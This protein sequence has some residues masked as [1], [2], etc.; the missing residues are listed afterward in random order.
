M[1]S[2]AQSQDLLLH[3]SQSSCAQSQDLFS[4]AQD[5]RAPPSRW[6]GNCALGDA[7]RRPGRL[8]ASI[9]GRRH[10]SISVPSPR[11]GL[12]CSQAFGVEVPWFLEF[13]RLS[14]IKHE[15]PVLAV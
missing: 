13:I 3:P 1:S 6:S 12:V 15:S 7:V 2:C 14:F 10:P 4:V 8:T 11:L 5:Y 9:L